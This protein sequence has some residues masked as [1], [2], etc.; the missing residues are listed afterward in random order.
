MG[1]GSLHAAKYLFCM[2]AFRQNTAIEGFVTD[3]ENVGYISGT[4][5]IKFDIKLR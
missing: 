4:I 2:Q 5:P 3:V 1:H